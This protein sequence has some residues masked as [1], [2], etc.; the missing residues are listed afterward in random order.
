MPASI[1]ERVVGFCARHAGL[2]V[3]L[4]LLAAMAAGIYSA[5][6]FA[7]NSDPSSLISPQTTWHKRAAA[8]DAEFPQFDNT[9]AIVVDGAT[10]ELAER[11]ASQLF[12]A[13]AARKDLFYD[14]L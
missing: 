9:I 5:T 3:V 6:H 13:L 12:S 2:V 4:M 1:V 8:Y 7:L 10:P 11:A 14:V